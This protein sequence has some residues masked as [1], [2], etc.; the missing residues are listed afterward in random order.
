MEH[1]DHDALELCKSVEFDPKV[2]VTDNFELTQF[3]TTSRDGSTVVYI[4]RTC[5]IGKVWI[6]SRLHGIHDRVP[7]F[8]PRLTQRNMK[9]DST[10]W[11]TR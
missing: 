1:F 10:L 4:R 6:H 3:D 9:Q 7:Q 2:P 8:V 5:G 11:P